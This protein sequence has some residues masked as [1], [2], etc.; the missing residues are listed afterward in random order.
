MTIGSIEQEENLH[1]E[2]NES[3]DTDV[4]AAAYTDADRKLIDFVNKNIE[5]MQSHL[6]SAEIPSLQQ[7]NTCYMDYMPICISLN[8]LYQKV[9]LDAARARA[10]L[11]CFDSQAMDEAKRTFNRDD[12]KKVWYSAA[13][14]KAA[15]RTK[16]K[17]KYAQLNAKLDLAEGRRSFIER[18]C[19]SWDA[20]QFGLGQISRN[21]IAEAQANGLDMKSQSLMPADPD[22]GRMERLVDQAMGEF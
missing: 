14:L 21:L 10:E 2:V 5:K 19:K 12:N 17:A 3:V 16:Y 18:L 7:I 9:R 6:L 1:V 22:D 4:V 11:E 15:A 8:R 13:E 20:W